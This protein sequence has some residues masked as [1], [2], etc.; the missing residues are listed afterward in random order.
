VVN[1]GSGAARRELLAGAGATVAAGAAMAL[2]GCGRRAQVPRHAVKTAPPPIRR[3]DVRILNAAL[4][5]ER[6][7]VAA[8]TAG[9][10]LLSRSQ[11]KACKQ[12]LNE[13]LQHT[14]ELLALIKAAKGVAIPRAPSYDIGHPPDGNAVL[15]LLHELERE[16]IAGY[17]AAIPKLFPG[18]LRSAVAS[19]LASDA[20]H[21]AI[22]RLEQGKNPLPSAFVTGRE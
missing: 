15:A 20:Q 2:A 5:L 12:F 13:E 8:Y 7:T 4:Y 21:I 3:R 19:I 9:I 1:A 18:P 22:L 6:R 14:G 16:Q 17:L 11:A 10:P